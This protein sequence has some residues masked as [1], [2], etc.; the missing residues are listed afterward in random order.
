MKIA[1]GQLETH[2]TK[3]LAPIYLIRSDELLLAQEAMD[4]I[5]K[6]AQ[7]RGFSERS[8]IPVESADW[9]NILYAE[10]HSL[11][12]LATKRILELD[13]RGVKINAAN[14]ALI[15]QYASTP[16][17][18][19]LLLIYTNKLDQKSEQTAWYKAI[20]KAGV[21]IQIWPVA[22]DQLPQWIMQRAKE[23]NIAL[24]QQTAAWLAENVEGNLLAAAQE[25]EKLSLLSLSSSGN[26]ENSMM[27]YAHFDIFDLVSSI[28]NGNL[29][30]SLRI[31]NNL[32]AEDIEP[33][34]ILWAMTRELRTLAEIHQQRKQGTALSMLF[35]K[36]HIWDKRQPG[37][38]A[39]LKRHN[40][41]ACW[42]FLLHAAKI[43]RIIKGIETGNLRIE[44]EQFVLKMGSSGIIKISA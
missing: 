31:L 44:L 41:E 15:K 42:A 16:C 9:G 5:R 40:Q 6:A 23:N 13:L 3:T 34:L 28:L 38:R 30:R 4:T 32:L 11:S 37:V 18:D 7:Q 27:D 26:A 14:S 35:S 24:S 2:L 20:D 10:A 25:I 19:T 8:R 36:F 29:E 33:T 1:H 39:F 12:L 22:A 17:A 43:D 21:V